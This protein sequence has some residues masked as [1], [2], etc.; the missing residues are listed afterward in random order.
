V[1]ARRAAPR[2]P[3]APAESAAALRGLRR[4]PGRAAA[5]RTLRPQDDRRRGAAD[6]VAVLQAKARPVQA[7]VDQEMR[8]TR[9][10]R[11]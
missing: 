2:A 3:G 9:A 10:D 6:T 5:E 11:T 4:G 7:P 1:R 8:P